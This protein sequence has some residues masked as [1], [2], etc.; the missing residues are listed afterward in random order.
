MANDHH[1]TDRCNERAPCRAVRTTCSRGASMDL[2]RL[3]HAAGRIAGAGMLDPRRMVGGLAVL[4]WVVGRGSSLASLAQIHA[5]ASPRSTALVD[6]EGA[7]TWWQLDR[8]I[9]RLVRALHGLGA[10]PGAEV[11]LVLRNGRQFVETFLGAQRAGMVAAPLNTWSRAQEMAAILDR[12]RPAVLVYDTR[13]ADTL[14]GNVPDGT[15]LVH[16]GPDGDAL[17]GSVAYEQVLAEQR[18]LPLAPVTRDRGAARILIHTSGTTGVPKAAS[19]DTGTSAGQ[20]LLSVLE[21]VPFRHDDVL[22]IP[23]PMFHSLGILALS[24]G[25]ATG[26]AMVLP[27]RFDPAQAFEDLA[28]Y[29][30]TAAAFVPVMLRRMVDLDDRPDVDLSRLRVVMASGSAISRELRERVADK[31]GEVLYDLY[32]STE[33]GWVAI[34][35]PESI[36]EAPDAIGAPVPGVEVVLLDDDGN[37]VD[38]GE[39]VISVRSAATFEGYTS[40][41]ES[42]QRGDYLSTG[43]LGR[44]DERGYL[45]VV[46]RADDMVVVGGENVYPDEVVAVIEAMGTVEEATVFGVE[47]EEYGSVLVAYV[48]GDVTPDDVRGACKNDLPSYKVPKKIEIVGDLPRTATGKVKRKELV[49]QHG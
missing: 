19:R 1:D 2:D 14:E 42:D 34:A 7:L 35:T 46:G 48:V 47:D 17:D 18:P 26:A 43:D 30:V 13:N 24:I 8:R 11:A 15:R 38:D 21:V 31:F 3:R 22:Y 32:G 9:D 41:E 20:A 37:Q 27:D 39:G 12:Q 49:E 45:H 28:R 6:T 40:G 44:F 16:V 29:R 10:E 23:N 36:R 25:M 5:L 33:A 4:P